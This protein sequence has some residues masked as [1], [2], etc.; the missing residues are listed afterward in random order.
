MCLVDFPLSSLDKVGRCE[1]TVLFLLPKGFSMSDITVPTKHLH[2]GA[3]VG[4]QLFV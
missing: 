2:G 1:I 3:K 4:L